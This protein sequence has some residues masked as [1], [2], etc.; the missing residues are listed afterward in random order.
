[1]N[2]DIPPEDSFKHRARDNDHNWI[3]RANILNNEPGKGHILCQDDMEALEKVSQVTF[4]QSRFLAHALR[5]H[6]AIDGNKKMIIQDVLDDVMSLRHDLPRERAAAVAHL[7]AMLGACKVTHTWWRHMM[8]LPTHYRDG[9]PRDILPYEEK[10]RKFTKNLLDGILNH[11]DLSEDILYRGGYNVYGAES[12][13]LDH[14]RHR[15]ATFSLFRLYQTTMSTSQSN[16]AEAAGS[17]G[18]TGSGSAVPTEQGVHRLDIPLMFGDGREPKEFGSDGGPPW[19]HA[20]T[21]ER[22]TRFNRA[23]RQESGTPTNRRDYN[24]APEPKGKGK[25]KDPFV[26]PQPKSRPGTPR[27][28]GGSSTPRGSSGNDGP[29][30]MDWVQPLKIPTCTTQTKDGQDHTIWQGREWWYT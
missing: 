13:Y 5:M 4:R 20:R 9:Q 28:R 7:K 8:N 10:A 11:W 16:N 6:N 17:S 30:T 27:A 26:P 21:R 18:A 12:G 14:L 1:M 3:L 24:P 25:G 22:V 2:F 29:G 19:C 23:Q 15:E